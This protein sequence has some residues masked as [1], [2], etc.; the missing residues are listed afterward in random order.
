MGTVYANMQYVCSV[1]TNT[2][3][4]ATEDIRGRL[5]VL[6]I[7]GNTRSVTTDYLTLRAR[8]IH[9]GVAQQYV[10]LWLGGG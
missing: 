8:E 7:Q 10:T 3:Q 6:Q 1:M 2:N 5:S 9:G 4:G